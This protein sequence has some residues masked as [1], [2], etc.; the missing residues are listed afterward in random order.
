MLSSHHYLILLQVRF[1][2]SLLWPHLEECT[3]QVLP[4]RPSGSAA[5]LA[6]GD[7]PGRGHTL[8][9]GAA[10]WDTSQGQ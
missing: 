10:G 3:Q 7:L 9:A 8:W 5:S 4:S 2:R 1:R 6:P